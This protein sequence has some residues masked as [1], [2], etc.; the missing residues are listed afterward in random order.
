MTVRTGYLGRREFHGPLATHS[1]YAI[2][3][4]RCVVCGLLYQSSCLIRDELCHA[5][6]R[7][8]WRT[9]AELEALNAHA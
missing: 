9:P 5:C 8:G 4:R 2:P 1:P 7:K 3:P 6:W